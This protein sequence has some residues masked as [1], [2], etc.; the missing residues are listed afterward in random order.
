MVRNQLT[1]NKP[2][3]P[4]L[5]FGESRADAN[6]IDDIALDD[7]NIGEVAPPERVEL[8]ALALA[9]FLLLGQAL[10][11][12]AAEVSETNNGA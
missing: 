12:K 4:Y 11:T 9:L 1:W 3:A 10:V 7:A 8:L 6:Y 2:E 5:L